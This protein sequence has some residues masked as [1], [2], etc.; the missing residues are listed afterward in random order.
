MKDL[1]L[2]DKKDVEEDS[3]K[4]MNLHLT[5]VDTIRIATDLIGQGVVKREIIDFLKEK[6]EVKKKIPT[7]MH[8]NQYHHLLKWLKTHKKITSKDIKKLSDIMEEVAYEE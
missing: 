5:S 2:I 6:L 7:I 8:S 1:L 4:S 3:K